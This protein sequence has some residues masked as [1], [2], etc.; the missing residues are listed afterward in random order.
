LPCGGT[1]VQFIVFGGQRKEEGSINESARHR[2][3]VPLM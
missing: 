2:L 3:G 1:G